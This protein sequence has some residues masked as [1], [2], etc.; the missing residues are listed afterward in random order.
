MTAPATFQT[1]GRLI[2]LAYKDAGLVQD[3]D[4]P[5]SE[6]FADGLLR[7]TDIVNLLQTQGLKLWLQEDR[8]ISLASGVSIYTLGPGG[9]T[10]MVKPLR[11]IQAYYRDLNGTR[12]PLQPLSREEFTRLSQVTQTGQL[13]SYFV[14]KQQYQLAVSF[15]PVPDAI[16]ATGTAHLILQ[17]QVTSP[18]SLTNDVGFPIE[19]YMALRWGLA[20]ELS[21]GQPASIMQRCA[22]K[23]GMYLQVLQDWDVEDTS[24]TFIPDARGLGASSFPR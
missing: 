1:V 18:V 14:D 10:A 19:W 4:D 13:N 21:T 20:D 7:L 9:S 24:V 23:A 17:D 6:Q 15:W 8:S 16:A 11:V 2:R 5:S 12:R 22:Q 3:G